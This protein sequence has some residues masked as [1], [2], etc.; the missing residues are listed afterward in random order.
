MQKIRISA[1]YKTATSTSVQWGSFETVVPI[2]VARQLLSDK[3]ARER[4]FRQFYP[5]AI[6]VDKNI[7]LAWL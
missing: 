3:A 2:E 6:M 1:G 4:L 7:D 5:T